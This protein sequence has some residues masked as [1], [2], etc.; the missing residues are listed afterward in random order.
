MKNK[1]LLL[2]IFLFFSTKMHAANLM[3]V[4]QQALVSDPVYQQSVSQALATDENVYI[5][6]SNLLPNVGGTVSPS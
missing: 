1:F 6:L 5:S 4:Y 3:E 2:C